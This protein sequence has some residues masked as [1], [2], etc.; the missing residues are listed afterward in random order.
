MTG[1]EME[2]IMYANRSSFP[3]GIR[4]IPFTAALLVNGSIIAGM[5][6]FLA[7]DFVRYVGPPT[8]TVD[9]IPL[10]PDPVPETEVKTKETPQQPRTADPVTPDPLIK[11]QVETQIAGTTIIPHDP[12]PIPGP[13]EGTGTT[14]VETPPLPALIGAVQDPRYAGQFQPDY[15]A[16]EIRNAR[17]GLVSVRVL[18]GTDGRVK[19][20]EQVS[21]TSS[22]FFDATR[23]QALSKW[24]FKPAT[25]GGVPQESW[26]T[27]KVRFELAAER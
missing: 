22:A 11:T 14:V 27:M 20:V 6:F 13:A 10:P 25:R 26:K 19:A 2:G 7:P 12:P 17:E 8:T 23:R 18:I 9:T 15:P 24:R 1:L 3:L 16:L 21:A 4:P 5:I